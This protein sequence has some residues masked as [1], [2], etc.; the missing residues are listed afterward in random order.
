MPTPSAS[1]VNVRA[2]IGQR[3]QA[4][5]PSR[6]ID[7]QHTA[8]SIVVARE[9]Q[10]RMTW[11]NGHPSTRAWRRLRVVVFA[12][13]RGMCQICLKPAG[14]DFHVDHVVARKFGGGDDLANLQ[15]AC[16]TCNLHKAAKWE[17]KARKV[18]K[19]RPSEPHPGARA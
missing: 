18:S 12:R 5:A 15:L 19:R 6:G 10:S 11:G 2:W 1:R 3:S 8:A 13:D 7:E 14:S 17:S 9:A 16:R 4:W